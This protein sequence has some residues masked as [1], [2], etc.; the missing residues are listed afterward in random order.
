MTITTIAPSTQVSAFLS[1]PVLHLID[2]KQVPAAS[3]ETFASF[4]PSNGE[5]LAQVAFGDAEDVDRAVAAAVAPSTGPG[6]V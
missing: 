4:N 1:N 2:G 6:A 3:G 5:S